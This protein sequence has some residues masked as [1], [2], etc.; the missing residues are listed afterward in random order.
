MQTDL[1]RLAKIAAWRLKKATDP[2]IGAATVAAFKLARRTDPDRMADRCAAL[3]RRLGPLLREHRIGR[4]NLKA[5][6]PEKSADEIEDILRGVWDNLGRVGAEFAH[7]DRIWARL[8]EDKH[9]RIFETPES[10]ARLERLRD[11][12]KPALLFGAHLANWEIAA[13]TATAL[14]LDYTVLYRRPNLTA[15]A[16]AVLKLRAGCMG[17]LVPTSIEAPAK[18]A[19]VLLEGGHVGLMVDQ[20]NVQGVDVTFFGRR[21]KANPTLARLARLVEC[22]IHGARVIRRPGDRFEVELTPEIAPARDAKGQ[23]DVAGTMQVITSA[24]EAWV[25]EHPEQWLWVH[26]RWR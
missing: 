12:G 23:I 20:Y 7:L 5:A 6:F 19:Q 9:R 25:R 17:K 16:D 10:I 18:L 11:D 1:K 15:V 24:V 3:M 26:R 21:T 22:P 2:A 4:A 13:L 14:G 8:A